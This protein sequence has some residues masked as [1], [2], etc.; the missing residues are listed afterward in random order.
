MVTS[1][2][3]ENTQND[4]I[5]TETVGGFDTNKGVNS[6]DDVFKESCDKFMTKGIDLMTDI[7]T[8]IKKPTIVNDLKDDLL[9]RL[10]TE[11]E[12]MKQEEANGEA[13]YGTHSSEYDMVSQLFDNCYEDLKMEST[14]VGQLLP[15]KAIDFP[16]LIKQQLK[17]ATK[18]IL[19]TEVT[20]TPIVKKHIEQTYAIDSQ[21]KKRYKYPQCFFTDEFKELFDAGK[22]L[23]IKEDA[24]TLPIYDFK[25]A[26]ELTD[27]P[28]GEFTMDL[29]IPVV[30]L[31][32]G[33]EVR[34]QTPIRI[35]LSDNMWVNGVIKQTVT[36]GTG[37]EVEVDDI[38]TGT[39]DWVNHT[40]SVAALKGQVTAVKFKGYLSNTKN[41]RHVTFDYQREEREFKIEDGMRV[42]VPYSLE[43]LEDHKALMNIDLYQKSYN[44]ITDFLAQME[45]SMALK[46]LDEQFEAFDGVE[47]DPLEWVSFITKDNFDFD[48]TTETVALP[49]EYINQMLKFKID[50]MILDIADKAKLEDITFVIYGNPTMVRFLDSVVKWVVRPGSSSNG[51]K[52]DYGYG[53]MTS[54]DVKVQV[55][56]TK[57]VLK[58]YDDVEKTFAGL[59]FI[60]Y[61]LNKEQ[62]T[63]RHYKYTSHILTAQNSAYRSPE[64]PGGSQT[65]LLGVSRYTNVAIQGIQGQLKFT[66]AE[67]YVM[68]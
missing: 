62:F 22:G 1:F 12:N 53:V 37:A 3:N 63:F 36:D 23:P 19:Q 15:I 6:F 38:V 49:C 64:L 31:D 46:W 68:K 8:V 44:N 34:L 17:L 65:Y 51:V 28:N 40:V 9:G 32:D 43:Q 13:F 50:G 55:V 57:K 10:A 41:E 35:N 42:D 59:R 21:T 56:S 29:N 48:S 39:V 47:V 66:N 60:P 61:P 16:I 24:V 2:L 58:K 52:L 25:V 26:E 27:D 7:N 18:D 20:P 33:T 30:V 45:D 67:P 54:A 4:F 11:C 5:V 14:R